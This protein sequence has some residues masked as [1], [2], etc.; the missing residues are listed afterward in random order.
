MKK[1]IVNDGLISNISDDLTAIQECFLTNLQNSLRMFIKRTGIKITD[2][3]IFDFAQI[4]AEEVQ[5]TNVG[6]IVWGD[7]EIS[8]TPQTVTITYPG[9]WTWPAGQSYYVILSKG[10]I[11]SELGSYEDGYGGVDNNKFETIITTASLAGY[12]LNDNDNI[13]IYKL[14]MNNTGTVE[15]T[16]DYRNRV[17]LIVYGQEDTVTTT[18]PTNVSVTSIFQRQLINESTGAWKTVNQVSPHI[19]TSTSRIY[20]RITWNGNAPLYEVKMSP[21]V[22]GQYPL[23]HADIKRIVSTKEAFI[24]ATEGVEYSVSVRALDELHRPGTYSESTTLIAGSDLLATKPSP[25]AMAILNNQNPT[26]L[27]IS[28][29]AI[30]PPPKPYFVQL[31]KISGMLPYSMS[32]D[33]QL[34]YEGG[35]GTIQCLL[36]P[37]EIEAVFKARVVGPGGIC[38]EYVIDETGYNGSYYN[39]TPEDTLIVSYTISNSIAV[40]SGADEQLWLMNFRI[41]T[42]TNIKRALFLSRGSYGAD[43]ASDF[44]VLGLSLGLAPEDRTVYIDMVDDPIYVGGIVGSSYIN[45]MRNYDTG[46]IPNP[47]AWDIDNELC[48]YFL[49]NCDENDTIYIN[50]TL[51]LELGRI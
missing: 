17:S 27:S 45:Y 33:P 42:G 44:T 26:V 28:I 41:P 30:N 38:S 4:A 34:I 22:D 10:I 16:E 39:V 47:T 49:V 29:D 48:C 40:T 36:L 43:V 5:I 35:P 19:N 32:L 37:N 12:P 51:V 20:F 3:N 50:G 11:T 15:L 13:T 9:G 21:I 14:T 46:N 23:E 6:T 18:T 1:Y 24:E 25:P 31:F 7:Y 8:S 2:I